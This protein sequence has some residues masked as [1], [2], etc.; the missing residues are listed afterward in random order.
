MYAEILFGL[1]TSVH[2]VQPCSHVCWYFIQS[3]SMYVGIFFGLS[4]L[5]TLSTANF[6]HFH[7][8]A[9]MAFFSFTTEHSMLKRQLIKHSVTK[10]VKQ[11][12]FTPNLLEH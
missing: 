1:S 7:G 6:F 10:G 11:A 2:L 8:H 4:T 12:L 3:C 5:S 9:C